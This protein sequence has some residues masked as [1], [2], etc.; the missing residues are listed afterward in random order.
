[1]TRPDQ[2]W[3]WTR[4]T[5][6]PGLFPEPHYNDRSLNWREQLTI[7]D[8]E[9]VR[10]GMAR[11]RQ[12]R[13]KDDSCK[14]M[15]EF[16][17]VINHC[18]DSYGWTDDDTKPYFPMWKKTFVSTKEEVKRRSRREVHCAGIPGMEHK[19]RKKLPQWNQLQNYTGPPLNETYLE[20]LS[21]QEDPG[22]WIYQSALKLRSAPYMGT[23]TMYKGGG[24]V[25]NLGL[26]LERSKQVIDKLESDEWVDP[27]TRALFVEFTVYNANI[28]LFGS[29][30]LLVEFMNTGAAIARTEVKV[31]RLYSYVG[32]WGIIVVIFEVLF[33]LFTLYFF[34]HNIRLLKKQGRKYLSE[35]WNLLEFG[36]IVMSIVAVAMYAMKTLMGSLAMSALKKSGARDYVNFV[37]IAMWDETYGFV[38]GVIV[39]C[40]TLKFIKMLKF[41]KNMGLLGDTV[42]YAVKD[43]KMFSIMFFIYFMAFCL[44]AYILFGMHMQ[45]YGTFI[46]VF[47]SL[48]AMALGSFDFYEMEA[49]QPFI[50]PIFFFLYV[51]IINI[52]LMGMFLT[53][54][55]EA[56][57]AVKENA[58]LQSNEYEIVDFM[59]G[60]LKALF[61]IQPKNKEG[62]EDDDIP[63]GREGIDDC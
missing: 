23:L 10:V 1:I 2:F 27:N 18:R 20:W 46:G 8:R 16:T 33:V 28:N 52:G 22:P 40:A 51:A 5:L 14:I 11:L 61:G 34:Q 32:G 62:E 47:E 17:K 26:T 30:I 35:F 48:F 31:F 37:T 54:I 59:V 6:L 36:Q 57:T 29:L 12:L 13:V 24:Y 45:S 58:E 41:N 38:V 63:E 42:V 43:L 60:K 56:F 9:T 3:A 4:Q 7:A 19:P 55:A 44:P 25:S 53:I 50:G 15:K 21:E 39:F 49:A